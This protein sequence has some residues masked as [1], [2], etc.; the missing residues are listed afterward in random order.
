MKREKLVFL[1]F[2]MTDW[3]RDR[4]L[5]NF[6]FNCNFW[7]NAETMYLTGFPILSQGSEPGNWRYF[8]KTADPTSE[9]PCQ[10]KG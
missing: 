3:A 9:V 7:L 8:L 2:Y 10:S 4:I 6:L 1:M 5:T